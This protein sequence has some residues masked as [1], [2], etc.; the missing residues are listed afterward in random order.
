M[1]LA[2]G[3]TI[4]IVDDNAVLAMQE[5]ELLA[6]HGY[7]S[8]VVHS[9]SDALAALESD[10]TIAL[11][12]ADVDLGGSLDGV[13]LAKRMLESRELPIVMVTSH[14]S[15][16]MVRRV[17][18]V[19]PYGYVLKSAGEFALVE[20]IGMASEL[21][22]AHRM[23][24]EQQARFAQ[25]FNAIG[26][27]VLL[28]E[29]PSGLI[30]EANRAT[31]QL[32]GYDR[33]SLLAM[34]AMDLSGE[35]EATRVQVATEA[36]EVYTI[37]RRLLQRRDGSTFLGE[38]V[39]HPFTAAGQH[40]HITTVRDISD[41]I[42]L[43]DEMQQREAILA[44]AQ[45]IANFGHYT[46]YAETGTWTHSAH[47]DE[48]FGIDADFSDNTVAGWLS[49][50]H[51]E[52]RESLEAYL[53]HDVLANHS[54][55]DRTYRIINQRSGQ[56][57]WVHGLGRLKFS[58][59]GSVESML[60]TIRDI[61]S[62]HDREVALRQAVS[63]REVLIQEI[64]H[65]VKNNLTMVS[66]LLNLKEEALGGTVDLS[67]IRGQLAAIALVHDRLT[68]IEGVVA[69]D[70]AVYV[71]E[72][73]AS[74]LE[75]SGRSDVVQHISLESCVLPARDVVSVGLLANEIITN[76][77]KYAFPATK[78]PELTVDLAVL[79]ETRH[80]VLTISN[81]G[82]PIP[83][84]IN[85]HTTET[86]GL[87]LIDALTQTLGGELTITREPQT[88]FTLQIPVRSIR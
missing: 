80:F 40:M 51:P 54:A 74:V 78:A 65:R 9:A 62:E 84:E 58:P 69:I 36:H 76:A 86:L 77:V 46:F 1:K 49:I 56:T 61:T 87:R 20:A 31:E 29:D 2:D 81:N 27:A 34:T 10:Q 21:F 16:E 82:T 26:D 57:R 13:D 72:L 66:S 33:E 48:I 35:P 28:I 73:V 47:L 63:E 42:E 70:L 11:V 24:R 67:D 5:Q 23:V 83:E 52:D 14:S 22:A 17:K 79:S 3:G 85:V 19:T 50:I 60:G 12:L 37:P 41:Y 55:F 59:S 32:F 15:A 71:P 75:T 43:I 30:R 44:E 88:T 39:I 64:N 53:L 68:H 8:R 25:L 38:L 18:A 45:T 7:R 6:R 4:L